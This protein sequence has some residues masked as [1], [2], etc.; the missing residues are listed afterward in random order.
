V[1]RGTLAASLLAR[2]LFAWQPS[3]WAWGL[4]HQRF[5]PPALGWGLCIVAALALLS[6]VGRSIEGALARAGRAIARHL[7]WHYL[8]FRSHAPLLC[9]V[10]DQ[11]RFVGA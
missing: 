4:N 10:P 7:S 1:V 5:L 9:L 6:P 3:M 8:A 2:A 11:L